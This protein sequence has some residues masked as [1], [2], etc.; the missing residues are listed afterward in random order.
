V[1]I[2]KATHKYEAWLGGQIP[3]IA[4]DLRRKHALMRRAVFP[5]LRATFYRWCQ[6]WSE[7]CPELAKG[8]A[9]LAVG[10]LHV[11]NFGTWRD[12]DGRLVW[13]INDFDEV[14]VMPYA[15]DLVRL[16]VSAQL[17][18]EA[19]RL[20][21]DVN[22]ACDSILDGYRD[23]LKAGGC[24]IVLGEHHH[25]LRELAI[26]ESRDPLRFWEKMDRLPTA[27]RRVPRS[28]VKAIEN[29]M[30]D[31]DAKYRV[32]QRTAGIGSLG[33][34]RY[35]AIA[36]WRGGKIAREAKALATSAYAWAMGGKIKHEVLY[37]DALDQAV[38]C[39]DPFVRVRGRWIVRR[40]APDCSRIE[41]SSLPAQWD[42][43]RLL[44]DMGWETA[45]IHCGSRKAVKLIA[46]DLRKRPAKWLPDAARA[47]A[48]ATGKD[49]REWRT[50]RAS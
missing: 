11:E 29:L 47:M 34:E 39:G 40:L 10:D 43:L 50:A 44:Y 8:P 25:W 42:E 46:Q 45:N 19:G 9:V 17:A 14:A 20:R 30:P 1:N 33:R 7:V 26:S 36:D 32:A 38:R 16:A 5:F 12:R 15:L 18:M 28:A 22:D 41:L 31:T 37:Q 2:H 49:W 4:P 48:K 13:G 23:A 6:L 35:T 3:L 24:P 21:I 27:R